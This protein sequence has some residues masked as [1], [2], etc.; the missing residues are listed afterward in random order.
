MLVC[1]FVSVG[2]WVFNRVLLRACVLSLGC[3]CLV[4]VALVVVGLWLCV[5]VLVNVV[6]SVC[7]FVCLVWS[8][9]VCCL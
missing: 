8:F 6:V 4:V 3:G 7:S 2:V 9:V 1:F 5:Y